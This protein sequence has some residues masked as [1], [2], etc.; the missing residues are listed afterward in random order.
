MRLLKSCAREPPPED[1]RTLSHLLTRI[2]LSPARGSFLEVVFRFAP[3]RE[4]PIFSFFGGGR[5]QR[6]VNPYHLQKNESFLRERVGGQKSL[7]ERSNAHQGTSKNNYKKGVIM[8]S[9]AKSITAGYE[10]NI[11]DAHLTSLVSTYN[12]LTHFPISAARVKEEIRHDVRA[13]TGEALESLEKWGIADVPEDLARAFSAAA[14]A[15]AHLFAESVR[16][17]T[18]APPWTVVGRS[19]Y[20]GNPERAR[21]IYE[22][23]AERWEAAKNLIARKLNKYN[24]NRAVRSDDADAPERLKR[25]I[26]NLTNAQELMK[27][28]NAIIRKGRNVVAELTA[29]GISAE[30]VEELV[31]PALS[32]HR[33][34]FQG[35]ELTNNNAN[36]RR[37]E[38][39]LQTLEREA[40]RPD[41][42]RIS[43]KGKGW[44]CFEDTAA[45]RLCY[46]FDGIPSEEVRSLL[47]SNG[48][49]W[50]P[51]RLLWVRLLN[52][53]ARYAATHHI[54]PK[55]PQA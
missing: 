16:E 2:E 51:T 6:G 42:D 53:Q 1:R 41:E 10:V 22:R 15:R 48:F 34:G 20:R 36:I 11:S 39:R 4:R 23:A 54:N 40:N 7:G 21:R 49:K 8:I 45:Q 50:S 43:A 27:K 5:G 9:S 44:E 37:L 46:R 26:A 35:W 30:R 28:V 29:L 12:N 17:R 24:P 25:K 3:G 31:N 32:Y 55:L 33:Q 19:N 18:I 52:A 13:L 14:A 38:A 47:K